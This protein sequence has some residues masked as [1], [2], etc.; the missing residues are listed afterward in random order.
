MATA[1]QPDRGCLFYLMGPSGAGKD[2]LLDACRGQEVSG[3]HLRIAPRYITRRA[4]SG[5]EDH[6]ALTPAVFRV[7][8]DNGDFALHWRANGRC[9][10]IGVEVDRWLANGDPVLV[11]GSRAHLDEALTQYGDSLVPIMV[12]VDFDRQRQ[13]LLDRGRETIEEI[14]ARIARSR[15]LQAR[16]EHRFATIHNDGSLTHA[17]RQLLAIID[18]HLTGQALVSG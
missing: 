3:R 12:C 11:N 16:L 9:Y 13:R 8:V 2:T 15:R 18:H 17:T 10:G 14:D 1:I 4:G 7:R 5:G 6:I